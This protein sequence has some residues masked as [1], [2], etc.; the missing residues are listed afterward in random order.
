MARTTVYCSEGDVTFH[1]AKVR[2]PAEI[3]M[4]D[5]ISSGSDEMDGY[6]G[7]RYVVPIPVSGSDPA[8]AYGTQLLKT[9][10]GQ[11]TAGR[12]MVSVAA[13]GE[14]NK[15]HDYGR[16]LIDRSLEKLCEIKEGK[17]NISFATENTDE[18]SRKQG[19]MMAPGGDAYS[20]VDQY[21]QN[22]EPYG[23]LPDRAAPGVA[24]WPLP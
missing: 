24:P 7:Y 19:P 10:C 8:K 14:K 2:L 23:F 15:T 17:L 16:Y 22:L 5:A 12:I 9:I 20:L 4:A 1:F 21:Y 3:S 11:L 18:M 13:G 6:L